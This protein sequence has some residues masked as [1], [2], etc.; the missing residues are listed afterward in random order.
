[1]TS[2]RSGM[3]FLS[4]GGNHAGRHNIVDGLPEPNG[5]DEANVKAVRE[6]GA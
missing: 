2:F 1:M 4:R 5:T 6:A 3:I